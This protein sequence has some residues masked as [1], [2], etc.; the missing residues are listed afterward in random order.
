[1]NTARPLI[2]FGVLSALPVAALAQSASVDTSKWLCKLC[3]FEQGSSGALEV[4]V[5]NVSEKSSRFGDY[6]GRN[7]KGAY[8]IGEAESRYRGAD[9]AYW[10]VRASDIG[11]DS[12]AAALEG[13]RQGRYRL[14]LDSEV[15]P[16]YLSDTARTPFLGSGSTVL[17]LPAG[18]PAGTTGLMPL[19]ATLRDAELE[20]KRT[21]IG[22]GASWTAPSHWQFD[23]S[24]RRNSR[25]GTKRTA[26]ALFI[27]AAQLV[28]PVD[29]VTDQI[30]ASASY[31]V[32]KLQARFA[33]HGSR[34]RNDNDALTWANPFTPILGG[35]AGQL[36]LPPD[37]Q[38]HQFSAAVGY[39]FTDRTRG[40]ADIAWGRM[41]QDESFL[42]PTLN[43]ALAVP[44]LPRNS[45]GGRANTLNASLKLTSALTDQLRLNASYVHNDRDNRTPQ[46]VYPWVTTDMFLAVPRTNLPYSFTQDRLKL[47]ADYAH[48]PRVRASA[49][50]DHDWHE[51]TY[52]E[53]DTSR[54]STLW[55][56]IRAR[57]LDNVDLTARLAYAER[58]NS[59]YQVVPGITP[60]ENPLLRKYNMANRTREVMG[61]RADIAATEK[62]S[63]G[64]GIDAADDTYED[65]SIGLTGGKDYSLN[66]DVTLQFSEQTS[67]HVFANHQ[68]IRS[69]Q[70]GSQAFATPDWSGENRDRVNVL[71]IGLK[72]AAIKGKLDLGAD[73]TVTRTRSA[74][75][76]N[77]GAADPAFP[78]I[79]TSLDSLKLYA[80]YH[81][82]N[83][84]SLHGGYW[85]ERFRS[86]D[87][88]L[89]GVTSA[90]I[91]NV[92]T[93]GEQ[94]PQYRVH[95]LRASVRYSF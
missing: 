79:Q 2:L 8:F 33:Y 84:L 67:L 77:A 43:A 61:L 3:K 93:F 66:G 36:A 31:A 16:H 59:G 40:S 26:G 9:G 74:I 35:T 69:Q 13:G 23:V 88:A 82:R 38:F 21:R 53:V 68:L 11:L 58:R 65:S 72:H 86:D 18:F 60:P 83:D 47:S 55:G 64:L 95:V 27:N 30:D 15:V 54:E 49:G 48:T 17:G 94:A 32:A 39:Q 46:A 50:L 28:E 14:F 42:A 29:M 34:F 87:W 90:T 56:K 85:Y 10:N 24:Y 80:I 73:Y 57:A 70:A 41:T 37:N 92:L 25:F 62:I 81:I 71:G 76:V 44:A 12:R 19:A 91:P 5:G 4:G 78:N 63:I 1:M 20:T 45:L 89:D 51:R 22:L 6:T 52:Q 7:D 75:S